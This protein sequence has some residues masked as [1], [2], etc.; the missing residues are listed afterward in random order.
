LLVSRLRLLRRALKRYAFSASPSVR[1]P[2]QPSNLFVGEADPR[3]GGCEAR[4]Q[5]HAAREGLAGERRGLA[6]DSRAQTGE[7]L[8]ST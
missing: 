8:P 3:Q 7:H 5:R 1:E 2:L 4:L 6:G